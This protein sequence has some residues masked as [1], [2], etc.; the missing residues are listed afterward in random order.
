M[1]RFK[2]ILTYLPPIGEPHRALER[3]VKLARRNKA[4]L[5][6]VDVMRGPSAFFED[7]LPKNA[8]S[9]IADR[10]DRLRTK[11]S[12]LNDERI[13]YST[14][15][16]HGRPSVKII[17]QVLRHR[18]DL[19][20]KDIHV[21]GDDDASLFF[22]SVDMRLMRMCPC[23][24]W[25]VKP[26]KDVPFETVLAAIDCQATTENSHSMNSTILE[27]TASLKETEA[28]GT[29]LVSAWAGPGEL[30]IHS[31]ELESTTMAEYVAKS[32]AD[33]E[34]RFRDLVEIAGLSSSHVHF[35]HGHPHEAI[36]KVAREI[37]ANLIV[38]GTLA[39]SGIPG[40]LMGNTAEKVLRSVQCSVLALKPQ[41]FRS[42]IQLD[43]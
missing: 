11:T 25:L 16:L 6:V 7:I 31:S 41:G 19:V 28:A 15:V 42:P 1:H 38:M 13:E 29:H 39:R 32:Q 33:A 37:D 23:P 17:Q 5:T 40:L 14:A 8:W 10:E 43:D 20:I 34:S 35:L 9:S 12:W 2:N 18:H 30:E 27:L 3:A 22:G 21:D 26:K 36:Q 4:K 24:V